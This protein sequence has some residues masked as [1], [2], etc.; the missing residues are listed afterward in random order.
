[1]DGR[2]GLPLLVAR[3]LVVEDACGDGVGDPLGRVVLLLVA[4]L[5]A[6]LAPDAVRG[7]P[8]L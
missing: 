2:A 6:Q 7:R 3:Q 8:L 5:L 1:V 4:A